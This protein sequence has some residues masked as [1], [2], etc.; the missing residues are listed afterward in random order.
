MYRA[1]TLP[2]W[3]CP[4]FRALTGAQCTAWACMSEIILRLKIEPKPKTCKQTKIPILIHNQ[5]EKSIA[6]QLQT[7]YIRMR[8]VVIT[9]CREDEIMA[10]F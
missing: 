4:A 1:T 5:E 6:N 3:T 10:C 2:T 9:K 7:F 8:N